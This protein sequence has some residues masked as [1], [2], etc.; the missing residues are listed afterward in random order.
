MNNKIKTKKRPLSHNPL[1][2]FP[3]EDNFLYSN[4]KFMNDKLW[5]RKFNLRKLHKEWE[6][7]GKINFL[8]IDLKFGTS[9]KKI[10]N[11]NKIIYKDDMLINPDNIPQISFLSPSMK[12]KSK[13]L[14]SMFDND[15]YND[16]LSYYLSHKNPWNSDVRIDAKSNNLISISSFNKNKKDILI[17]NNLKN[18]N[19]SQKIIINCNYYNNK[20]I[21]KRK[22][23][24]E[25]VN[26]YE[27]EILKEISKKYEKEIILYGH[28]KKNFKKYLIFKEMILKYKKLYKN[29]VSYKNLLKKCNSFITLKEQKKKNEHDKIYEE[30][31]IIINY[32]KEHKE[33][34][35]GQKDNNIYLKN[36]YDVFDKDEFLRDNNIEYQKYIFNFV[37]I[38]MTNNNIK[39]Y[40]EKIYNKNLL[41]DEKKY[42]SCL[43]IYNNINA[44]K[45]LLDYKISFFHPGTY[46]LFNKGEDEYHAW[47][48][49]MNENKSSKG[50]SKKI[51]KIPIFN[52]D[53]IL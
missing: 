34:L 35:N 4:P 5:K 38:N 29:L 39:E 1:L 32:L 6:R 52:Y 2:N 20:Y 51:E 10:K 50:C 26:K 36:F 24:K 44:K 30:L 8:N 23:L 48:C 7:K 14:K 42:N 53:I 46:Y 27:I 12:N 13:S 49:C 47:S 41:N 17:K 25:L 28:R 18:S 45:K 43:N 31:Y 21:G 37:D 3:H 40:S 22:K 33:I 16:K 9:K 19:E 11:I 15:K